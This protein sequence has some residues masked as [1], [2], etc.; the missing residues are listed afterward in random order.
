MSPRPRSAARARSAEPG[1]STVDLGPLPSFVGYALR[2]AQIAVFQ[3]F[4]Q[5]M[6]AHDV[7]PA[8]Y[9]VLLLI[10]RNPGVNQTQLGEALGIKTA[11]LVV[12]LNGLQKRGLTERRPD[13]TDRRAHA[14]HLTPAGAALMAALQTLQQE[15][16]R[17]MTAALGPDGK[18]TLL[19]LLATLA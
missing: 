15:H 7:R 11:N 14:L 17:R 16:E 5:T 4:V 3:D 13:A 2:R 6:A 9:S 12:M 8:Q 18:R 1:P 19:R 10:D